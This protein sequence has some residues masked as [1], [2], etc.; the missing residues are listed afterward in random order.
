MTPT[1]MKYT[2]YLVLACMA[3]ACTPVLTL[4]VANT[5][6]P[7]TD[8]SNYVLLRRTDSAEI[9]EEEIGQVSYEQTGSSIPWSYDRIGAWIRGTA[10]Q[11]GANLVKVTD[12]APYRRHSLA[13]VAVTLTTPGI[14]GP[15][16]G[17]S[18][19]VLPGN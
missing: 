11:N 18:A 15:M 6:T 5:H 7:L 10:M 2:I 16:K 3:Y 17:R 12:F 1:R 4:Q 8:S 14:L 9:A 19:G 13:H